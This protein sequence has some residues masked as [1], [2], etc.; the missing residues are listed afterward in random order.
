MILKT[1]ERFEKV[2][3]NNLPSTEYKISYPKNS[4]ILN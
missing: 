4:Q 2:N 1:W 3:N